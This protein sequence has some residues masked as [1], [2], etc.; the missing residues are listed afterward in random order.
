M[1][2]L[3]SRSGSLLESNCTSELWRLRLGQTVSWNLSSATWEHVPLKE[4]GTELPP[5]SGMGL[6][7]MNIPHNNTLTIVNGTTTMVESI[8]PY[9]IEFGRAGCADDG[10]QEDQKEQPDA[11]SQPWIGFNIFNPVMNTWKSIDLVSATTDLGFDTTTTLT[12]G[13]WHS[14]TVAV[15]YV[16]M[17]WYIILQSTVPLRQVILKNDVS[18]LTAFMSRVDLTE[19]SSTHFPTILLNEGW[20]LIS[21]LDETAPFVGKG[22]ATIMRDSIV[23]ISGTANSFTPGDAQSAELRGCDHAYVFSLATNTWTR[24]NLTVEDNEVIPD[25]REKAA[26][27]A[28]TDNWIWMRGP[29]GPGPRADHTLLQYYDYILAVSGFDVGRNVPVASVLPVMA[30]DTNSTTWT[31]L[32]RPT[33]DTEASFI[34]NMTRIAII[35]GTVVFAIVL[36][37]IALSTHLLRKWNQ[38]NYIKVDESFQLEEQRMMRMRTRAGHLPS[39]LK[40]KYPSKDGVSSKVRGFKAEVI[41]EHIE[42]E[43]EDEDEDEDENRDLI[44]DATGDEG[45]QKVQK[46]SLLSQPQTNPTSRPLQQQR[47]AGGQRRVRIEVSDDGTETEGEDAEDEDVEEAPAFARSTTDLAGRE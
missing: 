11:G 44:G 27:L 6:K 12:A 8:S 35:V 32:I 46:M 43:Y 16:N 1:S 30:Y 9:M 39:I 7:N 15:D 3:G 17:A 13:N 29:D 36:L 41:F 14:P 37:V 42:N 45:D 18:S 40:K 34:S 25:T 5:V 4:T 24:Q 22:V 21:V 19:S 10:E 2:T 26:F 31:E 38:R 28:D 23:I 47:S 20:N 33:L